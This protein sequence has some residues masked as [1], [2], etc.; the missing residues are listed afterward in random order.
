M[1]KSNKYGYS[2]VDIPTQAFKANV[3][4]FDPAE[5][6]ELVAEDKWTQYGQLELIETQ[7]YSSAVT[8][9][10]FT[11][12]QESTYNVHFMTCSQ[13]SAAV[14]NIH[15]MNI[16]LYESGTLET[17]GVYYTARQNAG[18]NPNV[19]FSESRSTSANKIALQFGSGTATGEDES[20][21]IYFYNLGDS[22][23]YS[24]VTWHSAGLTNESYFMSAFG[25]AALP[26]A[27]QVDGIRL[28]TNY[29]NY[30]DFKV[31]L[32]GIRYS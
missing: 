30:N 25:S 24:Y 14:D 11:S 10:D 22:S 27:S 13:M 6:N 18:A 29:N 32:Y 17:G 26:Q 23:N 8:A 5:I 21:Y 4:K 28:A 15:T 3:G 9:I 1:S 2:G 16:R 20:A 7:T 31:S 12:I 19:G